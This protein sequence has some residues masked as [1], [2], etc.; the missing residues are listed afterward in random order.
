[1]MRVEAAAEVC[2][3]SYSVVTAPAGT[4]TKHP[5][6]RAMVE[7]HISMGRTATPDEIAPTFA[8]FAPDEASYITGPTLYACGGLT[9]HAN[10]QNWSS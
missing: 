6:K 5:R 10:A 2:K 8:F 4:W 1:M 9:L 3:A 7:D